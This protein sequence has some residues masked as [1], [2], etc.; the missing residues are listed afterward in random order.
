M[1]GFANGKGF[2][3][4]KRISSD[5]WGS[6]YKRIFPFNSEVGWSYKPNSVCRIIYVGERDF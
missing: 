3:S 2:C 5:S 4:A 6:S 1:E